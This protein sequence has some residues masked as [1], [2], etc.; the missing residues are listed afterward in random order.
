MCHNV[1]HCISDHVLLRQ[2][3]GTGIVMIK[4]RTALSDKF[5]SFLEQ[6]NDRA[7]EFRNEYGKEAYTNMADTRLCSYIHS[8][9]L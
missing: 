4:A 3:N 2:H 8:T 9:K 1:E 7:I 5:K 6:E